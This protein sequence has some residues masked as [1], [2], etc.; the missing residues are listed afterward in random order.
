MFW[1][2]LSPILIV[3]KYNTNNVNEEKTHKPV[4]NS[5]QNLRFPREP[6]EFVFL[7]LEGFTHL[8]LS[9]S[10]EV[11]RVANLLSEQELYRWSLMSP[12]GE[13]QTSSNGL[14][15]LVDSELRNLRQRTKLYVVSGVNAQS[16]GDD[17]LYNYL[18]LQHR[19]GVQLGALCSGA[20]ILAQAGLLSDHSCSVHWEY[21]PLFRENFRDINLSEEA[22]CANG[23]PFTASGGTAGAELMLH[24][25]KQDHDADFARAIADQLVLPRVRAQGELQRMPNHIRYGTRNQILLRTLELM[26]A[27]IEEPL[28]TP[29]IAHLI[30]VSVRQIERIFRKY[31]GH[32]PGRHYKRLRL[33]QA[34]NLLSTTDMSIIQVALATGFTSSSHFS[35]VFRSEFGETP[36]LHAQ[37]PDRTDR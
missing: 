8:A 15:T 7:L 29:E 21:Y 3:Y 27:N 19:H 30:G 25:I 20:Y 11:L 10:I 17:R 16:K 26:T 37:R 35:K 9:S 22:F 1:H 4:K 24:L 32:S 18:R 13:N 34:K 31:I 33:D 5:F 23:R 36:Y 28:T 12:Q 2:Y 6:E 14:V